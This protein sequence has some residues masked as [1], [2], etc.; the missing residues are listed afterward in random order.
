MVTCL[1]RLVIK[2]FL[3]LAIMMLMIIV[4]KKVDKY[5]QIGTYFQEKKSLDKSEPFVSQSLGELAHRYG[6]PLLCH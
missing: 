5:S 1:H 2:V 3:L 6:W 4:L